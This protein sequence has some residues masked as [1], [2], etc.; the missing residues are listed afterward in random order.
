[1]KQTKIILAVAVMVT[2][3]AYADD[4]PVTVTATPAQAEARQFGMFFGGTAS[5][6]DLCV[7]KGFLPQ[8]N[9]SAEEIAKSILPKMQVS[10]KGADQLVYVQE[11][12]DVM[13]KEISEHESFYTQDK[14]TSVGK[15]WT[16]ILATM[17]QK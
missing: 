12:W 16:K 1:M 10:N 14:C 7:K 15:E 3:L 2:G 13:K 4:T 9:Q 11:G 6:Y 5:Q 8:G 17:N